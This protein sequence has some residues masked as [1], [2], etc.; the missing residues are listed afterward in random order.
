MQIIAAVYVLAVLVLIHSAITLW[1]CVMSKARKKVFPKTV[2]RAEFVSSATV[3]NHISGKCECEHY[4]YEHDSV[5]IDATVKRCT[6]RDCKCKCFQKQRFFLRNESN[7]SAQDQRAMRYKS[8]YLRVKSAKFATVKRAR[9][10]A[11]IAEHLISN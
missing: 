9:W 3:S 7:K 1:V 6:V 10:N 4:A 11:S 2:T 5:F 8:E